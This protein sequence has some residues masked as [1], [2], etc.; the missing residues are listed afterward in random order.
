M[1]GYNF[2]SELMTSYTARS[3]SEH[4]VH[5]LAEKTFLQLWSYTNPTRDQGRTE[6]QREGKELCD[7]LV[8]CGD[9]VIIFS[10][11]ESLFRNSGDTNLDW[12][13]WHKNAILRSA[14]QVFGAERFIRK[15][16]GIVKSC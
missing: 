10:I 4:F 13:R 9:D 7:L 8:V 6:Q 16:R 11:K 15:F 1:P 3:E 5:R 12:K 2:V 14:N